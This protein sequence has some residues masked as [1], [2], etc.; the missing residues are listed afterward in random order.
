MIWLEHFL[1]LGVPSL[2]CSLV[3]TCLLFSLKQKESSKWIISYWSEK[4]YFLFSLILSTWD[5]WCFF[6]DITLGVKGTYWAY[7]VAFLKGSKLI[8]FII[9]ADY[10]YINA[11]QIIKPIKAWFIS[12]KSDILFA[13]TTNLLNIPY[14][15]YVDTISEQFHLILASNRNIYNIWVNILIHLLIWFC[16]RFIFVWFLFGIVVRKVCFYFAVLS[17]WEGVDLLF[18]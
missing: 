18:S 15:G 8:F 7:W 4:L 13:S 9:M 14:G 12:Y 11:F 5:I 16:F 3:E 6:R 17:C 10:N 2:L 1:L